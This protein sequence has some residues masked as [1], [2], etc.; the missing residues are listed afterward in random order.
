[1][2]IKNVSVKNVFHNR[3][4]FHKSLAIFTAIAVISS[5]LVSSVIFA[6]LR[7]P[8]KNSILE[9]QSTI[10]NQIR[11]ATDTYILRQIESIWT[12][13][14]VNCNR[15]EEL[16]YFFTR[17]PQDE[18][19][20]MELLK[21][22]T[23]LKNIAINF[24]FL[25]SIEIYNHETGVLISSKQGLSY[26]S[27]DPEKQL[28]TF[29]QNAVEAFIQSGELRRW[30]SVD[31]NNAVLDINNYPNT[32]TLLCAM[33]KTLS[34]K[35]MSGCFS[36]NIQTEILMN[37]MTDFLTNSNASLIIMENDRILTHSDTEKTDLDLSLLNKIEKRGA[38][39][40]IPVKEQSIIWADSD[41]NDWKYIAVMQTN[42]IY[43]E[44]IHS[45]QL[46]LW[47]TILMILIVGFLVYYS[48][49]RLY[50][51][52]K[53][54][55]QNVK[56]YNIPNSSNELLYIDNVINTLST[57]ITTLEDAL[58]ENKELIKN[59]LV[60]DTINGNITGIEE[61]RSRLSIT[62]ERFDYD[63]Y[64]LTFT[65]LNNTV[66]EKMDFEQREILFYTT[67]DKLNT[68]WNKI[69]ACLSIRHSNYI[70]SLLGIHSAQVLEKITPSQMKISYNINIGICPPRNDIMLL[71]QDFEKLRTYMQ[72][73]YI[74]GYGCI[75]TS[76][77]I[78]KYEETSFGLPENFFTELETL[79]QSNKTKEIKE[80]FN[81]MITLIRQKGFSYTYTQH[82]LLQFIN[83]IGKH[84]KTLDKSNIGYTSDIMS[85]F[86]AST[87][88]NIL[89]QW[90]DHLIDMYQDAFESRNDNIHENFVTK[91]AQY[92]QNNIT[93]DLSLAI[94]ADKFGISPSYLSK[95]FKEN[96][97]I[98]FSTFLTCKK[99][100]AA[101]QLL[102]T[103]KELSIKE[104]AERLGYQDISYFNQ[105]FKKRFGMS[106]LQYRKSN[107]TLDR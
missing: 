15:T 106:P 10:V 99:F 104:I 64:C 26:I 63:I 72:Y 100:E 31:E 16:N 34:E 107:I 3:S 89:Q 65:E 6:V 13:Y 87:D 36:F 79:L 76:D 61:F 5:V 12:Q 49:L 30:I 39:G 103:D 68:F 58:D 54:L 83:T 9:T 40:Y 97:N 45:T 95:I 66:L 77:A 82:I 85:N 1:M 88:L 50:Q 93:K 43:S 73:N 67:F 42:Q 90:V 55:V 11:S 51:P 18:N 14:F 59:Q 101:A 4:Y 38:S 20:I 47:I 70:I 69:G 28:N 8:F 41:I 81:A 86:C 21:T 25:D 92:I 46:V 2:K 75:F 102:I 62:G 84:Y 53:R 98:N 35:G 78:K 91:I 56:Q 80:N 24:P 17:R 33:P 22:Y 57:K 44:L 105:Q 23:L 52:I 60:L 94:V 32:I 74:Y 37:Y 27:S 71:R 29:N 19:N 7:K 96:L 48:T